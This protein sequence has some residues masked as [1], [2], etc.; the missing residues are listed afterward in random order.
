MHS[1]ELGLVLARKLLDVE[2]LHYGLWDADLELKLGNLAAAQQRYN[3]MLIAQ[4]PRPEREVRV[5]DIGCGTGQ[6]LRQLLD[7]GYR[8]D[9]VIP[10]KDLG[11]AVRRKLEDRSGP[12][13]RLRR[14]P[15]FEGFLRYDEANALRP[16]QGR[17]HHAAHKSEYGAGE[18]PA[19][20]QDQAGHARDRALRR[21]PL[22]APFAARARAAAQEARQAQL[23]IFLRPPQQ[24]GVRA[25]QG[26]SPAALSPSLSPKG[27]PMLKVTLAF[28]GV[29]AMTAPA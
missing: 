26:L 28:A 27:V 14:R 3:D 13:S 29:L 23:Q 15:S 25:L 9:G 10:L 4:L 7:R 18:R 16:R 5:L 6:L 22:S 24:G 12:R 17:G 11:D 2:D 20:E 1:R 19:D 21:G 8:A